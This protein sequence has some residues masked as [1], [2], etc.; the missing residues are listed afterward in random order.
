MNYSKNQEKIEFK[1]L[2]SQIKRYVLR[3]LR[4]LLPGGVKSGKYP[5]PVKLGNPTIAWRAEGVHWLITSFED[6]KG[7]QK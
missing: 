2:N 4:D 1:K 7:G 5:E 6:S 3:L